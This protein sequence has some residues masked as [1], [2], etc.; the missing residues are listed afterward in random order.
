M[1]NFS[2]YA[3]L[4]LVVLLLA[5]YM[6]LPGFLPVSSIY[7]HDYALS[8]DGTQITLLVGNASSMGYIRALRDDQHGGKLYLTP[9]AAFGGINGKIGAKNTYVFDLDADTEIIALYKAKNAYQE[10]LIKDENGE[11]VRK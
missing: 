9:V 8:D 2:K 10:A 7:I 5:A 1:K 6:I 4:I 3:L 11:W